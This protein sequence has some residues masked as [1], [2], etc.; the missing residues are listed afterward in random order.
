MGGREERKRWGTELS[1]KKKMKGAPLKEKGADLCPSKEG[2]K[3][4]F[5]KKISPSTA[6]G[7][8]AGR[9]DKGKCPLKLAGN[10]STLTGSTREGRT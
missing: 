5:V 3:K 2:K 7:A 4:R 10:N 6:V 9:R 1:G 8:A